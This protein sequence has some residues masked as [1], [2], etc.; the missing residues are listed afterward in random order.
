MLYVFHGTDTQTS[1]DKAHALVS[2]LRTK[3]PDASF[4]KIDADS[5]SRGAVEENTGGQGLFSSKYIVFL[6]RVTEDRTAKEELVDLLPLMKESTNIFIILEGKVVAELKKGFEKYA[7]KIVE[8]GDSRDKIQ[9]S[10]KETFNIFALADALGSRNSLMSWT[11]YRQAVEQGIEAESIIGTLFWQVKSMIVAQSAS[12]APASGLS[13]FV[14][15]KAKKHA[16]NY[17]KE[18]L[19]GLLER[20]VV[21]YHDAHRGMRD[22]ELAVERVMLELRG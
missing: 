13:P 2:S 22:S 20:L 15:S 16:Q 14:F 17:S 21:I 5:W 18:E 10:S 9:D 19:S 6:D 7:E 11:L 3:R 12:T 4:V 1:V 8:T